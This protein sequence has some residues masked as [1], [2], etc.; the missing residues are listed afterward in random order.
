MATTLDPE[1]HLAEAAD[2]IV[3]TLTRLGHCAKREDGTWAQVRVAGS[4]YY[5][6]EQ[7]GLVEIDVHRLPR[8]VKV[9]DLAGDGVVHE[10]RTA[11]QGLPVEA[12]NDTGLIYAIRYGA[13]HDDKS[14]RHFRWPKRVPL[15]LSHRPGGAYCLPLGL[16]RSGERLWAPA[17]TLKNVLL[18]GLPGSGKST[19][20]NNWIAALVT[21]HTPEEVTFSL[22][23][24]KAIE[25]TPWAGLPHVVGDVAA[26]PEEA[27]ELVTY[28]A[29][30]RDRRQRLFRAAGV[31]SLKAY[32]ANAGGRP[33][34][35]PLAL[36]VVVADE[37]LD[38]TLGWGGTKS[39]PFKEM[40]RLASTGRAL[41]LLFWIATQSPRSEIIDANFKSLFGFRAAFRT[42]SKVDSRVIIDHS[43]AA[44]ISP[45]D[46]GVFV[47]VMG[48]RI[49]TFKSF[50]LEEETLA[51]IRR[52]YSTEADAGQ[53]VLSDAERWVAN[54]AV[55]DLGGRFAIDDVYD[56]TGPKSQ[57]G[58]SKRWL[59]KTA[60]AWE[61][62]G[63][64]ASDSSKPT[65]P[66]MATEALREIL[67]AL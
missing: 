41:G 13:R 4:V 18:G 55:H 56:R 2:T 16:D 22:V 43:D 10:L 1:T 40:L 19:T 58:V 61:R 15:D 7:T 14:R 27:E 53:T 11:L 59:E 62:R 28:L 17:T 37:L 48:N 35:E 66:R 60:K 25:L 38:L 42:G 36:H 50:W 54:I 20:L 47:G 29:D 5:A 57:G 46:P 64:L 6:P 39:K 30:E 9:A 21:A 51:G 44:M 34:L 32:N 49:H 24:Q 31:R 12:V 3:R 63:W 65:Q 45:E 23:D 8:R 33:D 26:T 67:R 52:S